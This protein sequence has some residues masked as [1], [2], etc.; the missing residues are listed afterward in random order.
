MYKATTKIQ[1]LTPYC[2]SRY[3][4][5]PKLN[6]EL[7]D[8]YEK[9]TWR[10]RLHLY[11]EDSHFGIDK[12][13]MGTVFIPGMAFA[14]C[15]KEAA[16]FLGT[17]IPGKGKSTWTKHF[18]AGVSVVDDV[19][20]GLH[21]SKAIEKPMFV[22]SNGVKGAGTRVMKSYPILT[23]PLSVDVSFQISDDMI[24]PEVFV[25]HLQQA[26]QLIGVG[27]FR[28]R[29]SGVFG[30]FHVVSMEWEEMGSL[31]VLPPITY[32]KEAA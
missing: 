11:S 15:V 20:T 7:S 8:D 19:P 26:G 12:D 4:Q 28:V 9:R 23:P 10:S 18:E 17:Q 32:R 1:F 16:K 14:N 30:K 24:T 3:H 31:S 27:S 29:N 21:P 25:H 6:K 5:E 13:L 22:P 2:Q